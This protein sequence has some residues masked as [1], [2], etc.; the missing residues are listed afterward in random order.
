MKLAFLNVFFSSAQVFSGDP[1]ASYSIWEATSVLV[2][3]TD[4]LLEVEDNTGVIYSKNN[5]YL[6]M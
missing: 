3:M 5:R 6:R 2:F 1:G 4:A